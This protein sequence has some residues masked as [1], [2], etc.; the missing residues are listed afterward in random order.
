ME[1]QPQKKKA[2]LQPRQAG[3]D[4]RKRGAGRQSVADSSNRGAAYISKPEFTEDERRPAPKSKWKRWVIVSA[5]A[6]LL[7]FAALEIPH[8]VHPQ[9][10]S[11]FVLTAADIDQVATANARAALRAGHIPPE[12]ANYP[13]ELLQRIADGDESLY[14]KRLLPQDAAEMRVHVTITQN[15]ALIDDEEL[16]PEHPSTRSF[17]AGKDSPTQ[18]HFTVDQPGPS[19]QVTCWV[20]S[21]NSGPIHTKPMGQGESDDLQARAQ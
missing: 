8:W 4:S 5:A 13:K 20:N 14:T 3:L 21:K 11:E 2:E 9:H 17:P 6:V 19:H 15:G 12:L 16:T 18:F 10:S 1:P 7:G